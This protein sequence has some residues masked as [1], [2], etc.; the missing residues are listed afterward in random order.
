MPASPR[1]GFNF[2]AESQAGNATTANTA[3]YM[4]EGGHGAAII[5]RDLNTPPGS[6]ADGDV[7]IVGPAPTGAWALKA[8][9]LA[10]Y[11]TGTGWVFITPRS[12]MSGY[13]VDEK[14][15][16]MYSAV[17]SLWFPVTKLWSA[18]E[19]WT[20]SYDGTSKV[21]SKTFTVASLISGLN[22]QAHGITNLAAN[23]AQTFEGYTSQASGLLTFGIPGVIPEPIFGFQAFG[24][25]FDAFSSTFFIDVFGSP[26]APASAIVRTTYCRTG[27]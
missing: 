23:K 17:E 3:L 20:G 7:Y 13:I 5:D 24:C 2:L 6:P 27:L 22:V 4:L 10:L 11:M 8:G 1:F 15:P 25:G 18:T 19:H 26:I 14:L 9:K 16:V 12:G 21:F